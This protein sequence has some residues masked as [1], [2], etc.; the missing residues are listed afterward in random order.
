MRK[1]EII[2]INSYTD[3]SPNLSAHASDIYSSYEKEKSFK[4]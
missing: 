4:K 1:Y 2:I 3:L